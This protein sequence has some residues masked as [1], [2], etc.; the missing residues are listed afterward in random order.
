MINT[1]GAAIAS[2]AIIINTLSNVHGDHMLAG[3]S[4]VFISVGTIL[5]VI[6]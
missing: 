4:A 5:M 2:L 1:I 6:K 3:I